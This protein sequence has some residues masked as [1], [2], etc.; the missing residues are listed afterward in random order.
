[1]K[2][3]TSLLF[4]AGLALAT[5][6]AAHA[7]EADA[8]KQG[9]AKTAK[10]KAS[11]KGEQV[12]TWSYNK[13]P[14]GSC[15]GGENAGG[16]VRMFYE[17]PQPAKLTALE[18]RKDN[19]LW[20]TTYQRVIF[21]PGIQATATATVEGSHDAGPPPIP[22]NCE[23]NGGGVIP[24]PD[25]CGTGTA[26]INVSLAYINKDRLL[27]RG[28]ASS[29]DPGFTE[30]RGLFNNCPYWQGGPYTHPTAEGDLESADVKLKEKQLFD[31]GG[32]RKFVLHGSQ[33]DCWDENG[34][35][36]CGDEVGPFK[37]TTLNTWT[38]TMKRV[39]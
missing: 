29:W 13:A 2:L 34:L 32:K 6:G 9:P 24:L 27:V 21:A 28:D 39:G 25:E 5:L 1:M 33:S 22:E 35:A 18:I 8:A 19:P 26:L 12:I 10:F 23:D 14:E 37:G 16:S 20:E 4:A 7:P 30:L 31:K 15:Y 3:V 36:V 38:L 17:A 11:I